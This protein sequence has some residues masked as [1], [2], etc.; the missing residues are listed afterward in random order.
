MSFFFLQIWTSR[1]YK[2]I[3]VLF[4]SMNKLIM[5]FFLTGECGRV[6]RL[7]SFLNGSVD[8]KRVLTRQEDHPYRSLQIYTRSRA[9]WLTVR[10]VII[11]Q[12]VAVW[13]V[14]GLSLHVC[15]Q[16]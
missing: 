11:Q 4:C 16:T 15:H 2:T 12:E 6:F 13:C 5:I 3:M 1:N 14:K 10:S 7:K 8:L 9:K